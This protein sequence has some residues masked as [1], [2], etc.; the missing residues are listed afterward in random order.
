MAFVVITG[1]RLFQNFIGFTS[2]VVGRGW[3]ADVS[4]AGY[5]NSRMAAIA[6]MMMMVSVV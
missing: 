3:R 4:G 2:F 6:M 1:R 5:L